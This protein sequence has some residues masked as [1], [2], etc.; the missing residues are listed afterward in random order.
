VVRAEKRFDLS[1]LVRDQLLA[2][3]IEV[4]DTKDGVEWVLRS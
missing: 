1:D 4:R 2:A 3:G